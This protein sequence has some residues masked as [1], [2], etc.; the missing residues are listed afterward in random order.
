[1][2]RGKISLLLAGLLLLSS[3]VVWAQ[4]KGQGQESKRVEQEEVQEFVFDPVLVTA[5]RYAM[6]EIKIP[7]SVQVISREEIENMGKANVQETLKYSL[8]TSY[9]TY[10][11]GGASMSSMTSDITIRGMSDGT[12]VL[13]NGRPINARGL[14]MLEKFNTDIVERIE[15]VRGGGAVMYGSDAMG[16]VINIITKKGENE[17]NTYYEMGN[18]GQINSGASFS[19]DKLT[20]SYSHGRWGDVGAVSLSAWRNTVQNNPTGR[21]LSNYFDGSRM[22][23]TAF[24]Y[25][26]NDKLSLFY[27]Y[28][29][30]NTFW[31]YKFIQGTGSAGNLAGRTRYLRD[32]EN[33]QNIAQ[34]NFSDDHLKASLYYNDLALNTNGI[35]YLT[36]TGG[37]VANPRW[38]TTADERN[39]NI[40]VD[41][42]Y[43]WEA[44]KS[45]YLVGVNGQYEYYRKDK[46]SPSFHRYNYSLY[47]SLDYSFTDKTTAILS[48]RY[49]WQAGNPNEATGNLSQL[50][51]Q[52][53]LRQQVGKEDY[54]YVSVSESYKMPTLSQ[55]FA[56]GGSRVE[57]DPNLKPQSGEHYELGWKRNRGA[58]GWRVALFNYDIKDNITTKTLATPNTFKYTNEDRKNTGLELEYTFTGKK[59]WSYNL[60]G[61]ISDPKVKNTGL[62][63]VS[64]QKEWER[65]YDRYQLTGGVT[66]VQNN[67]TVSLNANYLFGRVQ[68]SPS[69]AAY[70]PQDSQPALYTTLNI[71]YKLGKHQELYLK[72][73]NLLDRKD[74]V[75]NSSSEY[76]ATPFNFV[77]GYNLKF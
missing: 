30:Q 76:Y 44:G 9:S 4:E 1:M 62:T 11:P 8:G 13:V 26:F 39:R 25:E 56:P 60:G 33:R 63:A 72:M 18:F 7:A 24:T 41:T 16:G 29:K 58:H 69:A 34:L 6:R 50:T 68:A 54:L 75:N 14:H 3:Q 52:L 22:H 5:T 51:P 27:S 53:Q 2:F 32:Y 15:I 37:L 42:Q 65:A 57:G 36:A 46:T 73:E 70:G 48:M 59:G 61:S 47:G 23:S 55:Q 31:D 45:K 74:V 66:Y 67:W 77:L 64:R 12:L 28:N 43:D 35:D 40:G 20:F 71:N 17:S 49:N 21:Y 10:G 19:M 38:S